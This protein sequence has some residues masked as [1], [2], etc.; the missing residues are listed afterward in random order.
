MLSLKRKGLTAWVLIHGVLFRSN[1]E[2]DSRKT[3]AR[4]CLIQVIIGSP[5][6][7]L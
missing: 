2:A 6:N 3:L 5:G 1:A 7:R 4:P